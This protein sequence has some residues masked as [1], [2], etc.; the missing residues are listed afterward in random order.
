[1]GKR[2]VSLFCTI[3]LRKARALSPLSCSAGNGF[4]NDDSNPAINILYCN[5]TI[6]N[7]VYNYTAPFST[8]GD[9]TYTIVSWTPASP[10]MTSLLAVYAIPN[11][12]GTYVQQRVEGAGYLGH[13]LPYN[14]AYAQ[15]LNRELMAFPA[16]IYEPAKVLSIANATHKL[17][18]RIQIVPF[19]LYVAAVLLYRSVFRLEVLNSSCLLMTYRCA[20]LPLW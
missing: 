13:G 18:S 10:R 14:E 5:V 16:S 11:Y 15:E 4:W 6:R 12:P 19:V 8:S 20:V 3:F 2:H 9:G 17:G 7:V 1:L